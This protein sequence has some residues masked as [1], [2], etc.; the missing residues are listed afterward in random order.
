MTMDYKSDKPK[1]YYAKIILLI[2]GALIMLAL[3][4]RI[5]LE[6]ERDP[7]WG[8]ENVFE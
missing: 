7:F 1:F 8:V 2:L 5:T 6:G 4:N 3:C